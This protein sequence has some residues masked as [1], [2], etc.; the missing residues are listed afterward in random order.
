MDFQWCFASV[1]PVS[2]PAISLQW[3]L[4][5]LGQKL[6][7]ARLQPM[8]LQIHGQIQGAVG[9]TEGIRR[10]TQVH[11][12]HGEP[13]VSFAWDPC[14]DMGLSHNFGKGRQ[15]EKMGKAQSVVNNAPQH[16]TMTSD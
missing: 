14:L 8:A 6:Q 11:L 9:S 4:V 10:T 16:A 13:V 7:G 12:C 3:L 2:P 1:I 15:G 5:H